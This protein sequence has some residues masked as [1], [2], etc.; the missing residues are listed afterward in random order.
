MLTEP[1]ITYV[2][3]TSQHVR[4]ETFVTTADRGTA[5]KS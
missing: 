2:F 1:T 5:T 3:G 4:Y